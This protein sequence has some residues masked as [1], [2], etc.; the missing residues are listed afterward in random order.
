M[1]VVLGL[2]GPVVYL[3][4]GAFITHRGIHRKTG[5]NYYMNLFFHSGKISFDYIAHIS[6]NLNGLRKRTAHAMRTGKLAGGARCKT[7]VEII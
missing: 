4:S 5:W 7:N 2:G 3:K 6:A 1:T